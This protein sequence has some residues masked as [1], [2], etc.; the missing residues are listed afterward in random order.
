MR[1]KFLSLEQEAQIRTLSKEGYSYN[2]IKKKLEKNIMISKSVISNILNN[3]GF[4]RKAGINGQEFKVRHHKDRRSKSLIERIRKMAHQENPL[5]QREMSKRCKVSLSTIN[6]I[7]HE[8][9]Y[10][11]TL[12]KTRVNHL[13]QSNIERQTLANSTRIIWQERN[14]NML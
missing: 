11:R 12:K 2:Q 6:R 4:R 1:G 8:D 14:G 5:T 3:I 9:L 10:L 13:T 7:I